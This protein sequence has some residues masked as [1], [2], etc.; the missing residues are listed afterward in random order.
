MNRIGHHHHDHHRTEPTYRSSAVASKS[1]RHARKRG[2]F[3]EE[4]SWQSSAGQEPEKSPNGQGLSAHKITNNKRSGHRN[5]GQHPRFSAFHETLSFRAAA[6]QESV[7]PPAK[8]VSHNPDP[9]S[10]RGEASRLPPRY[11]NRVICLS[12]LRKHKQRLR[13]Q[14]RMINKQYIEIGIPI[15]L[16]Q[17]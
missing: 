17:S 5:W 8:V 7:R 11:D 13:R 1:G 14:V 15:S 6:T 4:R 10:E 16:L 2:A 12:S 9:L 3:E